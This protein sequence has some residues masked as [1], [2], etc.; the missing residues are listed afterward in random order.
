MRVLVDLLSF[1]LRH[2]LA[3]RRPLG[4][5]LRLLRWQ[6]GSRLSGMPAV[7]PFVG[8]T[9]LLVHRGMSSATSNL[10]VGLTDVAE[11]AFML[12]LLRPGDLM[13]DVG[14]NVGVYTVL[15]AGV[16]GADVAAIEPSPGTLPH[17]RDN[18]RL[19]D[20][21][22]R[23]RVH[24]L[25][26]GDAVGGLFL[27]TRRGAANRVRLSGE[28]DAGVPILASTLDVVFSRE[29]P[30]LLKLDV[31]GYELRV[32][33]GGIRLLSHPALR[34]VLAET[35]QHASR[36]GDSIERIDD[37]LRRHGFAPFDYDPVRRLLK[38]RAGPSRPNTMY[39]RDLE[40]ITS[41]VSDA[42]PFRIINVPL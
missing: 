16:A 25:A 30:L 40:F 29:T 2:P 33:A 39:L 12:H 9:R 26:M 28:V 14:A 18:I 21:S 42:P 8:P 24:P 34:A 7:M 3:S 10:Y 6:L 15:A 5:L 19:N 27:T 35:V 13:G 38:Q 4:A 1:I 31:E 20:L 41:R 22:A 32:L 23:V 11:M 37:L 17:L 36:Y